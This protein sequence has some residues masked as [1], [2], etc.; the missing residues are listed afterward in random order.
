MHRA[1]TC[2]KWEAGCF[3]FLIFYAPSL[4]GPPGASSNRIVHLSVCLSICPSVTCKSSHIYIAVVFITA[5]KTESMWTMWHI[6]YTD[7]KKQYTLYPSLPN[8]QGLTINW[9]EAGLHYS[10][11][12]TRKK[13]DPLLLTWDPKWDELPDNPVKLNYGGVAV[14]WTWPH[15]PC[16][17][18]DLGIQDKT[19]SLDEIWDEI[20]WQ[21]MIYL[22][23]YYFYL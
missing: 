5:G 20:S 8:M 18:G 6:Y 4:K 9:Q 17:L 11:K 15:R 14:K 13:A 10:K 1:C 2:L 3:R 12:Q 7:M 21:E 16:L 19:G 23:V 22:L